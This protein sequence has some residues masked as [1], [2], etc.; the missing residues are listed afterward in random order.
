[1]F[2]DGIEGGNL[3]FNAKGYVSSPRSA[4]GV[5]SALLF[6][7]LQRL[8]DAGLEVSSPPTML[9]A[10]A[11]P[12]SYT[13]LDVYKRQGESL[14]FYSSSGSPQRLVTAQSACNVFQTTLPGKP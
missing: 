11:P 12:V 6:T 5:R 2:L 1:M 14:H 10:S 4:Y 7:L 13:H 8:H 9:L 3:V